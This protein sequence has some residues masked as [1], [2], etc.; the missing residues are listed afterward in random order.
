MADSFSLDYLGIQKYIRNKYPLLMID[1]VD[2]VLPGKYANG[3][4]N[5]T[6]N[7]WFFRNHF[8]GDNIMPG[9]LQIEAITQMCAIAINT[10]PN[11]END[12]VK[13]IEVK[14]RFIAPAVPGDKLLIETTIES[15]RRG[16]ARCSGK[17][18]INGSVICELECLLLAENEAKKYLP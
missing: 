11:M 4:K 17:G 12:T 8:P 18:I 6:N 7:D 3:Y 10:L 13:S 5:L 16:L 9:S 1:Y 14:S 2:D 15:F